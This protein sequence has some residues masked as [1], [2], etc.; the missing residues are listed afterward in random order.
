MI[1]VW[2]RQSVQGTL[3][4]LMQKAQGRIAKLYIGKGSRLMISSRADGQHS[5]G[6]FHYLRP[7]EAEDYLDAEDTPGG[8]TVSRF[9]IESVLRRL[10]PDA[11]D[12]VEYDWGYH[13]EHDEA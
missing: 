7:C 5:P 6:S 10:K 3:S 2:E 12:V 4:P 1:D 8:K 13:V 9:E 11:F